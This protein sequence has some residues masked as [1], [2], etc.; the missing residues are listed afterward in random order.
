MDSSELK[1]IGIIPARYGSTRFPG[2]PLVPI[3]GITMIE[4]V[5]KQASLCAKLSGVVVATD[6]NRIFEHVRSFGGRV[7]LTASS[8]RSGTDRIA[9]AIA[10]LE[11][12]NEW[13]D[14]VVNIQGDE[15]FIQPAQIE[16]VIDIFE[17]PSAEIG[18]L[19]KVIEK[20]EDIFDQNVVKV[21][22][23]GHGKALYFSRSPIPFVRNSISDNWLSETKFYKHIGI[24]GYRTDALKEITALEPSP[25]ENA[26]SLEQL[27]WLYNG[28]SVFTRI[29]D[30]ETIGIDSPDDLS[31][32]I[33]IP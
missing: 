30:I 2:K 5:Y 29:T 15:P 7:L 10:K 18:T 8:H 6:D 22:T 24:Y 19:V 13:Y 31:K 25:I 9:E 17:D 14:V 32:L 4:R 27:R 23:D 28:Y 33:N 11:G 3:N 12:H 20:G 16:K 21:V 1:V 26:E